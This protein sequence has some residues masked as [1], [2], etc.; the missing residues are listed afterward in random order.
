MKS[1]PSFV[2]SELLIALIIFVSGLALGAYF[3]TQKSSVLNNSAQSRDQSKTPSPLGER[4]K[5]DL[6]KDAPMVLESS[7]VN[8]PEKYEVNPNHLHAGIL[9]FVIWMSIPYT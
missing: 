7:W 6:T 5:S 1:K 9:N 2:F 8:F 3:F 4:S